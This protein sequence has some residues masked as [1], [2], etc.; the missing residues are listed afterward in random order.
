MIPF[1]LWKSYQDD[2]RLIFGETIASIISYVNN[3]KLWKNSRI[4]WDD[5]YMHEVMFNVSCSGLEDLGR[6]TLKIIFGAWRMSSYHMV[7]V[8]S[9]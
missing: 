4:S 3:I 2:K 6:N 1:L 9:E 8:L 5:L 7:T